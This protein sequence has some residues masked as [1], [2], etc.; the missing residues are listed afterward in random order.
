MSKKSETCRIS[1]LRQHAVRVFRHS[2]L[3]LALGSCNALAW[4][5]DADKGQPTLGSEVQQLRAELQA[6]RG[7]VQTLKAEMASKSADRRDTRES[8]TDMTPTASNTG[9][10]A[11]ATQA[12]LPNPAMGAAPAAGTGLQGSALTLFGY[13]ELGYTRPSNSPQNAS[14]NLT[15]GVLGWGY[16]FNPSTRMAAELELEGGVASAGDAGE[17]ELEQFYIAH[18][19][20]P[21]LTL[22]SGLFLMPAGYLNPS[23]EPATYYGVFRNEVETRIIPST[24]RELGVGLDGL[25][26][27]GWRWNTGLVTSPDLGKWDPTAPDGVPSECASAPLQCTHQEGSLAK[28]QGLTVYGAL[29]YDGILGLNV[30][31]SLYAGN[32]GQGQPGFAG[33]RYQLAE[34][35]ARWEPG[36]WQFQSVLAYGRFQHVADFNA[37]LFAGQPVPIPDSFGGAY[38]QAA[39]RGWDLGGMRLSPFARAE[40]VNSA[41]SYSG[42]QPGLTPPDFPVTKV[43]TSG[44]SLFLTPQVVFKADYQVF[45]GQR[46]LNAFNLGMGFQF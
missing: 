21:D 3:A 22:K 7:E 31:G 35:H 30:G 43:L 32:V 39:Y 34:L 40:V 20:R 1:P 5:D 6:L 19:I 2:T 11:A 23:H 28:A 15:R 4:A 38:L 18:D 27:S 13:G 8:Q 24:W 41:R 14:A 10:F 29:N 9:A 36:A 16:A 42:I 17:I 37:T 46:Q 25:S 45:Q 12:A 26:D 33:A 44:A